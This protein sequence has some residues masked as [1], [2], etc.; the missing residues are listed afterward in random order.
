[1]CTPQIPSQWILQADLDASH[2]ATSE[3]ELH[4]RGEQRRRRRGSAVLGVPL[5]QE[6]YTTVITSFVNYRPRTIALR[7]RG[8]GFVGH[9]DTDRLDKE[10]IEIE[11][12]EEGGRV[13][14]L[15]TMMK[16]GGRKLDVFLFSKKVHV[17]F[18]LDFFS[19]FSP[20]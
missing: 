17:R 19:L 5:L 2:P 1:M 8:A 6:N 3:P 11:E 16:S 13:K 9:H 14:R 15:C 10:E 7:S 12:R 18:E 4:H 20:Q